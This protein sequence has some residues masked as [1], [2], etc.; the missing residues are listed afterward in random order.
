[1]FKK[2]LLAPT[3]C[4][5]L[6]LLAPHVSAATK[7]ALIGSWQLTFTP[8]TPTPPAISIP[9]LATFTTDGSVIETDGSQVAPGPGSSTGVTYGTPGHGVWQLLPA[10]T[11][12]YI[13]Y[14]S[15][16]VNPD[17]SLYAKNVTVASVA[18]T[19]S[20]TAVT[21]TGQYTTTSTGPTGT[22]PRTTTGTLTGQLIP[23]QPLP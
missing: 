10:L 16:S 12:F 6:L 4:G 14:I 5:L 18:V 23:H 11:G 17:G 21:L 9:G 3:V 15:V 8:S 13:Q 1:M 19:G 20:G 2:T 7:P 22:P